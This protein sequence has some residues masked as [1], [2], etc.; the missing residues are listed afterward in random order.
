MAQANVKFLLGVWFLLLYFSSA[1]GNNNTQDNTQDA[2]GDGTSPSEGAC[3]NCT[4]CPYTC[5]SPPPPS[6]SRSYGVPPPTGYVNCPPAQPVMTCC[7]QYTNYGPPP[8]Y[9]YSDSSTLL[10]FIK[11]FTFEWSSAILVLFLHYV[12]CV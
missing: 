8:P 4:I 5:Q 3:T 11:L 6:G 9:Y 12:L 2:Y 7:P 1:F 10:P